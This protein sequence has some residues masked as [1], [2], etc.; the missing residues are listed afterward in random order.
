[1]LRLYQSNRLEILADRLAELLEA[2]Q[3][4][5]LTPETL[6]VQHPGMARWLSL[7]LAERLGVCANV[8][9]PLPA[10][11]VWRLLAALFPGLPEHNRFEP[12][13]LTWRVLGQ[14][15]ALPGEPVLA[16][17]HG[18]LDPG[19][20]DPDPLKRLQLAQRIAAVFDQ[21]LVY[22]PDWIL[23]WEAGRPAQPGDEWQAWLW[24]RL[25]AA[26][27]ANWV[28][29]Q[30]RLFA[31]LETGELPVGGLP[32]RAAV[33][34]VP[35]LSPGYLE[36][37]QRLG[38][39]MELHLF[40]LNPCRAH[41]SEIVDPGEK[42][43]REVEADGSELYLEVGNPL[44]ASL[45]RQGRDLFDGLLE[46]EA[47]TEEGFVAPDTTNLLGR[48]QADILDLRDPADAEATWALDP[49]DR[50]L[51]FHAC[52]SPT[53]ELEVLYDQL[54]ELFRRDP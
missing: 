38:E 44:L 40:L 43:R 32:A 20:G 49:G 6:V 28:G 7:R 19:G 34:G 11:F 42:A 36:I 16:P 47:E 10:A 45:G 9:F 15:D 50:S 8:E 31:A 24:R 18:Y 21:Y 25:S 23:A 1:M 4:N 48:V 26:G 37:L 22:R 27:D 2:P 12:G 33:F 3:G 30:Q 53:R 39:R 52:H 51:Q 14:L 46:V 29:L 13:V 35:T 54:L 41:W 5:P 17:L